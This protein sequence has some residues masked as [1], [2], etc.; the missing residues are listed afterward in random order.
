MGLPRSGTTLVEQVLAS[1][2]AVFGAGELR[3]VWDILDLLPQAAG[4]DAPPLDCIAHVDQKAVGALAQRHESALEAMG[5]TALRVVDKMPENTLYLGWIATLFPLAILIHCRRD[6]RDVACS[7]WMTH[8]AHVRWAC[9]PDHIATRI[10]DHLRLMDHW[11]QVLPVP[12]LEVDYESLVANPE[13]EAREL[14]AW[15]GLD[16]DPACLNFHENRRPVRT[17]SAAQ[18]RQPVHSRSVGRWKNYEGPLAT[19]FAK[20]EEEPGSRADKR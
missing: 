7:C 19:L 9:D 12:I 16:W 10:N 14:V 8:L 4:R 18:V 1:H 5:G 15:C 11:H 17:A 2:P 3:L 20:I 6:L 13:R